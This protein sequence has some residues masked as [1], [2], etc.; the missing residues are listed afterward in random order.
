MWM[1]VP[2]PETTSIIVVDNESTRNVQ[3]R[4][5]LPTWIHSARR[6]RIASP[7]APDTVTASR[8][9]AANAAPEATLATAPIVRSLN[10]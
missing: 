4:F 6:Q 3:S 10:L 1:S 2:T 9:D 5:R 7:W 8:T